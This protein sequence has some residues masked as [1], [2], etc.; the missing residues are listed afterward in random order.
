MGEGVGGTVNLV[1][2]APAPHPYLL[3]RCA[4]GAHQ[5]EE[6][7]APPIKVR[8]EDESE[9]GFAGAKAQSEINTNNANMIIVS[10]PQVTGVSM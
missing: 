6:G 5:P 8:G 10:S 9:L 7:W 3:W 4:M 2:S 1:P